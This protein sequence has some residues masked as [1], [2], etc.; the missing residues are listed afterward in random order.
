MVIDPS[1]GARFACH[2]WV[3][4]LWLMFLLALVL[5]RLIGVTARCRI[6]VVVAETLV[7]DLAFGC[8]PWSFTCDP[9]ILVRAIVARGVYRDSF[10]SS[11]LGFGLV[12]HPEC[13]L[14]LYLFPYYFCC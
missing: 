13:E 5:V 12:N 7:V 10:E 2:F 1:H 4:K 3:L 6:L 11:R 14:W 8:A 9:L